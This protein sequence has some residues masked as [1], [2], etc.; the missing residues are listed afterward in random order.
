MKEGEWNAVK[1]CLE[2]DSR[3]R[4]DLQLLSKLLTEE[5]NSARQKDQLVAQTAPP[6]QPNAASPGVVQ[7][8]LAAAAAN[9]P[10]PP[11]QAAQPK[12]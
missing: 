9:Q 5:G 7:S 12:A 3:A 8:T 4:D 2:R 11:P 6:P 1:R 10:G